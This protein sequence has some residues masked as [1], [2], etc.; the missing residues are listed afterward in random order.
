ML[1]KF[2]K[3]LPIIMTSMEQNIHR[4]FILL[5]REEDQSVSYESISCL[6]YQN[7]TEKSGFIGLM[8]TL[9][10]S[11]FIVLIIKSESENV[12]EV[13]SIVNETGRNTDLISNKV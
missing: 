2:N 12:C 11:Q 9:N 8:N 5:I 3:L 6:T 10:A 1:R 13:C 7:D 4:E